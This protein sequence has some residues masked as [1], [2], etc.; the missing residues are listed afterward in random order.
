M[1]TTRSL[2][3]AAAAAAG[4]TAGNAEA[5]TPLSADLSVDPSVIDGPS[6]NATL[7]PSAFERAPDAA[8]EPTARIAN[9][10]AH[11]Q[12]VPFARR[13]SGVAIFG[14]ANT[15]WQQAA[16]RYEREGAPVEGAVL[17]L[18]GYHDDSRGHVAVVKQIVSPR[19]IIV[20]HSNWL[21]HGEIT[22]DV[23]IRDVSDAGDWSVVQV[24]N[25][26]GRQW[27]A[28]TYKVRGFI[29]DQLDPNAPQGAVP[30]QQAD[31]NS[32]ASELTSDSAGG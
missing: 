23:P 2:L 21:N 32:A 3:L 31:D 20:D 13:E 7:A 25:V 29:L 28:R 11:L 15:W 16:G 1:L 9:R 5:L 14:D 12:C 8:F 6:E 27:G 30:L 26:V 22:R 19:L 24:W 18:R 10:R 4:F 17:V